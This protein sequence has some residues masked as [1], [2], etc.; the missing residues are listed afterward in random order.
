[1]SDLHFKN[2]N[3]L[4]EKISHNLLVISL[5]EKGRNASSLITPVS[6]PE[7]IANLRRA[8]DN[9]IERSLMFYVD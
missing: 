9:S 3:L 7:L 4:T 8:S 1:M 6:I 5:A 2:Y